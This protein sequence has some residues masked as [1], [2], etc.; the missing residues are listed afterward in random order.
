MTVGERIKEKRIEKGMTQDEL[1]KKAGYKSRSSINK[2]ELSRDLPLDKVEQVA[3]ILECSP[4]YLLGWEEE[5]SIE[6]AETDVAL[7]NMQ[8]RVKE[9]SL[10]LSSLP[11]EK[12]EQIMNLIDMLEE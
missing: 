6:A 10:K 9:Y 2:I 7:S 4:S 11:K 1:A 12:Q 8:K 5:F 3:K